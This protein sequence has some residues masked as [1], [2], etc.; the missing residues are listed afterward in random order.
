[1]LSVSKE[2]L[3]VGRYRLSG[4]VYAAEGSCF[5]WMGD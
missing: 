3:S 5:R 4:K 2:C 1:M